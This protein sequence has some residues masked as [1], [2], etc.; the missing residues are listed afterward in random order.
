[1]IRIQVAVIACVIRVSCSNHSPFVSDG[2]VEVKSG[3]ASA[4]A[5]PSFIS[6]FS[7]TE[8]ARFETSG[9]GSSGS[10]VISAVSSQTTIGV[11]QQRSASIAMKSRFSRI[12]WAAEKYE[13]QE[14]EALHAAR[15]EDNQTSPGIIEIG[16][17]GSEEPN[18]SGRLTNVFCRGS[19]VKCESF[20]A[21]AGSVIIELI[22]GSGSWRIPTQTGWIRLSLLFIFVTTK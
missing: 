7:V 22:K 18:R 2:S 15:A 13:S 1:M 9:W 21:S 5:L 6:F 3:C 14:R 8:A 12:Q 10:I 17:D 20:F 16:F 11:A 4:T 19:E